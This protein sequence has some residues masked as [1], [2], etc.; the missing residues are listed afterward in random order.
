MF[1]GSISVNLTNNIRMVITLMRVP[2]ERNQESLLEVRSVLC[3]VWTVVTW[4]YTVIQT[5]QAFL[6]G[7]LNISGTSTTT[8][9]CK[10]GSGIILLEGGKEVLKTHVISLHP[11]HLEGYNLHS[12]T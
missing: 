1:Y 5:H 9:N 4:E 6:H 7:L 12:R 2:T 3:F 11:T 10:K 8:K